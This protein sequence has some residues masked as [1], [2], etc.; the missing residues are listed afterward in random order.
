MNSNPIRPTVLLL[1]ALLSLTVACSPAPEETSTTTASVNES[2]EETPAASEPT[3]MYNPEAFRDAA[4]NGKLRVVEICLSEKLDVNHRD[5]NGITPLAAAAY[6]GH[7]DVVKLLL[8]NGAEVDARDV[9]GN[10]P[11]IHASGGE[12]PET[13]QAL[14]EAGAAVDAIDSG[15]GFSA[16]MMAASFGNIE[17]VNVLLEAGADAKKTDVDGDTALTFARKSGH[18]K[19]VE[20]L[21][22]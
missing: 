5:Q 6:N 14:L 1:P 11:L 2:A 12:Y 17:V 20:L 13:V 21:S 4:H 18:A 7:T 3:R 10:T 15:E 9:Q 19:I 22:N 8:E 16:L